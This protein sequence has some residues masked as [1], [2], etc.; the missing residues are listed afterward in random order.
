MKNIDQIKWGEFEDAYGN[1]AQ[2]AEFIKEV[3]EDKSQSNDLQ[4]GPWF[5]LWSRLYHQGSVYTASYAAVI[6]LVQSIQEESQ[7]FDMNF[8]LL[9][10]SIEIA[11][12][13]PDAPKVPE[14]L[15]VAYNASINGLGIV[16]KR[17]LA[18]ELSNPYM[19]KSA[20]VAELVSEGKHAEASNLIDM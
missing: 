18:G 4:S 1:A 14:K 5:E 17:M 13:K 11:R 6:V 20:R 12:L 9:P 3:V 2:V 15:E 16:A 8:I 19:K 7:P 10:V